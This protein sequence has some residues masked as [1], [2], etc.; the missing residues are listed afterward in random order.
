MTNLRTTCLTG[1]IFI[2]F[3]CF[4]AAQ[5]AQTGVNTNT[6][7]TLRVA[8][9]GEPLAD[10]VIELNGGKQIE[11]S[12]DD[13]ATNSN[14]FAYAI[15]HC[16]A[17]WNRSALIPVEY[18]NGFAGLTIDDFAHSI[19]TTVQYTNYRLLLPNSEVQFKVSGNY[20]VR[21]YREN[22]PDRTLLTACFSVVESLVDLSLEVTGRTLTD[23]NQAHQQVDFSIDH[24]SLPIANPQADLKIFVYQNARKDNAVTNLKPTTILAGRLLYNRNPLLIFEAGNEYRRMEFLSYTYNGMGVDHM[25]FHNPF[26][27]VTLLTDLPRRSYVYDE[28]QEGH[29]LIRCSR[30]DDPDTEA[31]YAIVHFSLRTPLLPDGEVYLQSHPYDGPDEN[32]RMHYNVSGGIYEKALLLKQGHYNY[33]YLFLPNNQT[34]AV[35]SALEGDFYQSVN[36]YSVFVYYRPFGARYDRLI[37][38]LSSAEKA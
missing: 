5:P 27:H 26:Y 28:D 8:P 19:A 30:C 11:I 29:Y 2:F 20:A 13:L 33:R 16:D 10:P 34:K 37:G 31:D 38:R 22:E 14:R 4:A 6:I 15:E 3:G 17:D 32:A 18:M 35:T 1:G 7:Y 21:I 12:F 25:G 23:F 9:L 24:R 36:N